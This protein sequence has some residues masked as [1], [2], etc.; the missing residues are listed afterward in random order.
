VKR[1]FTKARAV[2]A[3]LRA[4]L[5]PAPAWT[6]P[7][8]GTPLPPPQPVALLAGG[9]SRRFGSDKARVL[10]AGQPLLLRNLRELTFGRN[11]AF[12][13][14]PPRDT[15]ADLGVRSVPDK[16]PGEGPMGGLITALKY[17]RE[18]WGEGPLGLSACDVIHYKM[19]NVP[20]L[21]AMQ[22]A[23]DQRRPDLLARIGMVDSHAN[24]VFGAYH[25]DALPALE[26][27]FAD[28]ERSLRRWLNNLP[29]EASEVAANQDQPPSFNTEEE[30]QLAINLTLAFDA[31]HHADDNAHDN[32]E[33]YGNVLTDP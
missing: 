13:V 9:Q 7:P 6:P 17:R 18:R 29:C 16:T 19:A 5:K 31:Y 27:A 14:G 12:V 33:G 23:G 11:E 3:D 20:G 4:V 24:P 28:G 2:A 25:T 21:L 26:A 32:A 1:H 22:L 8:C 15:Y 30:L 10:V